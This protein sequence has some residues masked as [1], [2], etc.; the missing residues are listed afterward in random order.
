M[1]CAE[2]E[3]TMQKHAT[4]AD[5]VLGNALFPQ[6]Q[7]T[8]NKDPL[9]SQVWRMYTKAKDSLPNGSRLENLTWR[10]MAMTL[11]KSKDDKSSVETIDEKNPPTDTCMVNSIPTHSTSSPPM[12]GD[13]TSLLSSSAPPYMLDFLKDPIESNDTNVMVSGSSRALAKTG[14]QPFVTKVEPKTIHSI[15]IPSYSEEDEGE[16][17]AMEDT[18]SPSAPY[19]RNVPSGYGSYLL[20]HTY[21]PPANTSSPGFYFGEMTSPVSAP[22][23]P[24][25]ETISQPMRVNAGGLSFEE[26]LTMYYGESASSSPNTHPYQPPSSP[27]SSVSSFKSNEEQTQRQNEQETP[28]V[29]LTYVKQKAQSSAKTICNNCKTTTTPLWR[30]D[31]QGMPL[32]NACGLFLKLHGVVRPLSLKTDIIKKRNRASM[33]TLGNAMGQHRPKARTSLGMACSE[34]DGGKLR[35]Q[36]SIAPVASLSATLSYHNSSNHNSSNH[37]IMGDMNIRTT[38]PSGSSR[39]TFTQSLKKRQRRAPHTTTPAYTSSTPTRSAPSIQETTASSSEGYIQIPAYPPSHFDTYSNPPTPLFVQQQQ[40]QVQ[41]HQVQQQVQQQQAQQHQQQQQLQLQIMHHQQQQQQP[42]FQQPF[43]SPPHLSS[44]LPSPNGFPNAVASSYSYQTAQGIPMQRHPA[45]G[46]SS[47]GTPVQGSSSQ[48][49]SI[50]ESIG[51]QLNSLPPEFLPLVA[52][53]ANYHAMS[54]QRDPSTYTQP[55]TNNDSFKQS[56]PQQTTSSFT[57]L[58][59]HE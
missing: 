48:V 17:D 20:Q 24:S 15:A 27:H 12:P 52:S 47:Q 19:F 54:R 10:M 41:Q 36:D 23:T 4:I 49:Y 11:T 34:Q 7:Q 25:C 58:N 21:T 32:C 44:M 8:S 18:L 33:S 50:L 29:P 28:Q 37:N 30:R 6:T 2:S 43:S 35:S 13:T 42:A 56:P 51:N 26:L 45:Q 53:A 5:R 57:P 9:S 55:T 1:P 39:P 14:L 46:S 22:V 31:A 59:H 38:S 3:S 16:D 40:H